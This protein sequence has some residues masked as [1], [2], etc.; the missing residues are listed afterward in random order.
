MNRIR[1]NNYQN[2]KDDWQFTVGN[3]NI[4]SFYTLKLTSNQENK[5]QNFCGIEYVVENV[6]RTELEQQ[7]IESLKTFMQKSKSDFCIFI[8]EFDAQPKTKMRSFKGLVK[9]DTKINDDDKLEIETDLKNEYSLFAAIVR[10]NDSNLE[11]CISK[12]F[13]NSDVCF[14]INEAVAFNIDFI[15]KVVRQYTN[16]K[17]IFVVNYL[18]LV[19]NNLTEDGCI[20]RNGGSYDVNC[21][22]FQI[23]AHKSNKNILNQSVSSFE[24]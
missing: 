20:I 2:L 13:H 18:D 14:L 15:R 5:I 11:H 17:G 1:I 16:E 8:A 24:L 21:L 12:Y 10:I 3:K 9:R 4:E 22:S 7:Y 6:D 23:F 19:I